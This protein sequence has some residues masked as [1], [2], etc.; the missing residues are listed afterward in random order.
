MAAYVVS[1]VTTFTGPAAGGVP[2]PPRARIS[3]TNARISVGL[4][5]VWS[6]RPDRLEGELVAGARERILFIAILR[7]E[8]D[9]FALPP[10]ERRDDLAG[11][12]AVPGRFHVIVRGAENHALVELVRRAG[13]AAQARGAH[14][15][16]LLLQGEQLAAQ[17]PLAVEPPRRR[18]PR[19]A[20]VEAADLG[21]ETRRRIGAVQSRAAQLHVR[22]AA[23]LPEVQQVDQVRRAPSVAEQRRVAFALRHLRGDLVRAEAAE[24]AIQRDP[25][26]AESV[27]AQIRPQR[28]RILRFGHRM[29][30]PAVQL[31]ELLAE[32]ADVEADVPGQPGPVGVALFHAHGAVL[33]TDENLGV[34]IRIERRL[35]SNLELPRIEI[36]RLNA[37]RVA[38]GSHISRGADLRIQLFLV[39]L[40]PHERHVARRVG[41]RRIGDPGGG[42]GRGAQRGEIVAGRA[43]LRRA[44]GRS[45]DVRRET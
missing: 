14:A 32:F 41:A 11:D 44:R 5:F 13:V 1:D 15:R 3:G 33:E 45:A 40:A 35:E 37:G 23:E 8:E 18:A 38:V 4:V 24:R 20:E 30:M 31:T 19:E 2:T 39:A 28:E 34:R 25:G 22:G 7:P 26:A 29:Q 27:I 17:R 21:L 9:P 6:D 42:V 43:V 10:R 12:A 36:V 16:E